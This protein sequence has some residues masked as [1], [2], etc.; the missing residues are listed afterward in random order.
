MKFRFLVLFIVLASAL[1][2]AGQQYYFRQ[3]TNTEGLLHSFVYD[4]KQDNKGYLWIGTPDG[5]Y[6]FNGFDF[7]HF[8]T[9]DG[10]AENFI[11][12]IF[13]A[14]D[15][16][17]W[18]GHQ[19]GAVS[20]RLKNGFTLF[21]DQ[22]DDQGSVTDMTEDESGS[23]WIATQKQGISLIDR[24]LRMNSVSFPEADESVSR[25][26]YAGNNQFIIGTFENL[27]LTAYHRDHSSMEI[28]QRFEHYPGSRV[29]GIFEDAYKGYVVVSQ[30]DG[31]YYLNS[32]T[33]S[34]EYQLSVIDGNTDGILD[35]LQGGI[36]DGD[37]DLWFYS[38]GNGVVQYRSVEDHAYFRVA[39]ITTKNGLISENIKSMCEDFEGNLWFGM[40]GQ[41][42]LRY[43]DNNLKFYRYNDDDEP[44]ETY[45][46]AAQDVDFLV[47]T[48]NRLLK[49]NRLGDTIL[50]SYPL[51]VRRLGDMV[52][53]VFAA[54]DGRIWLGYEQSGLF[55]FNPPGKQFTPVP[56][57]QDELSNSVNYITG[58]GEY[59]WIGT[60]K[61]LCR[62]TSSSGKTRWYTTNEGLPHNHIRQ[63]YI[64]HQGRV[65]IAT[66]C[67]KIY[68]I[69]NQGEVS[70]LEKSYMGTLNSITSFAEDHD[71][72]LWAGT[73]GNGVWMINEDTIKNY[74]RV[75]GLLSDY[76]YG[77]AITSKGEPIISHTGGVSV[78]DPENNN[79]KIYSRYEGV[80][81][82]T[83][84]FPN[85]IFTDRMG[86][87]WFGTSEG[88]IKYTSGISRGGM[89]APM[90]QISNVL[91]DG[92]TIDYTDGPILLKPGQYELAVEYIG[93]SFTNPEMVFYQTQL[94]GYNQTWSRPTFSRQV[95][96]D[97]VGHGSYTFHIRA[98]NANDVVSEI[99][100]AFLL[101]IKK[102]IYLSIW[103]YGIIL[104]LVGSSFYIILRIREQHHRMVQERLLKNL[105]EKTKE[106]IIK[107]EIIKERKKVEKVL[108]EA[109]TKAELSEK[110]KTAFLQ[111]MSHE[112]RT[113]MN[114]IVGF[115]QMLS[116]EGLSDELRNEFISNVSTN[117][118][119]LLKLIDDILDLSMLETKQLKLY[120]VA[121]IVNAVI[122][123]VELI[124]RNKLNS[125]NK[126]NIEFVTSCPGNDDLKI[127]ADKT[128]LIQII[129]NLL[130]NALKYTESGTIK[131]GY[132]FDER[133]AI[134]FV[135]DTGIGLSEDK[136]DVVFDLFRKVDE[137]RFK[138]YGGTGLGLTLAKYLVEMMGGEIDVD[139]MKDTGSKFFFSIPLIMQN[140]LPDD[141]NSL[142]S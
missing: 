94:E 38:M 39:R 51:P 123:D 87:V 3:Y 17:I 135:E 78:I 111:N 41:G 120:K 119:S 37:G 95:V 7:E 43:V 1:E 12:R 46:I 142:S 29:T 86:N 97:R 32:D 40:Y 10:L 127:E 105:D 80:E 58:K 5:I 124:F 21:N 103:F 96:Y 76:C 62:I 138:L 65:L 83:E 75:S 68:Y 26:E 99:S 110:L 73:N 66:Q 130:D 56:I 59:I 57:S 115:T 22:S 36:M 71:G 91:I 14:S 67:N 33:L 114:A 2:A 139:S 13:R 81:S 35:N 137:D 90:I 16:K 128:R 30:E 27:Y 134:F 136:K 19:N 25:I 77:L 140:E 109:K 106:I 15:G 113:P 70:L 117:A 24:D 84:F 121:L 18:L 8:T 107:E 88:L 116:L 31:A 69:N 6:R 74:T 85:A 82:S 126:N 64:N 4:I 9:Q 92:D 98:Y 101:K 23:V 60:K 102:P 54:D 108:I 100:A 61:G 52:N 141:S 49:M 48:G 28:I 42:L 133:N 112:I 72:N 131:L 50:N 79:V 34:G 125:N 44:V 93:I 89:M 55:V 47:A 129:N 53:T 45:A 122:H 118:E 11:T 63:V 104:L 20:L 132:T